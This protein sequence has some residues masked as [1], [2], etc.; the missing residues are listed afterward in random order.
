MAITLQ[1]RGSNE[2]SASLISEIL[3][4]L[5]KLQRE[6][7]ILKTLNNYTTKEICKS[8]KISEKQFWNCIHNVRKQLVKVM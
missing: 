5:P 6:V 2:V 1:N 7:F 3:K 8:M 4:E